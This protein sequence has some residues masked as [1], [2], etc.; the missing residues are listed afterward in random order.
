M[1]SKAIVTT[2]YTKAAE[3]LKAAL[4]PGA[5]DRFQFSKYTP[6]EIDAAYNKRIQE[7]T[8]AGAEV[9]QINDYNAVAVWLP[10]EKTYPIARTD[11]TNEAIEEFKHKAKA[12]IDKFKYDKL[13][14]WTLTH[15]GKNPNELNKGS[16]TPLV[17][18]YLDKAKEQGISASLFAAN[19]HAKE[20]YLHWG[21]EVLDYLILG[22][23]KVNS[24]GELD[25]NGSGLK[26]YLMA[27]NYVYEV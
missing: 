7:L 24:E 16:I 5:V 10:P 4:L 23:G 14:H 25:P 8:Q 2:N 9:V 26:I 21:F 13:P 1:S 12:L 6:E 19:E 27:Y 15:I 17:R 22:E 11:K 18:P 3:T 20:V